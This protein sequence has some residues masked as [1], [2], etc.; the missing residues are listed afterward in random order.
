[1]IRRPAVRL[2]AVLLLLPAAGGA[3]FG[4]AAGE[5]EVKAAFIHNIAKFI[6]WPGKS[7]PAGPQRLCLLGRDGTAVISGTLQGKAIGH[8]TWEPVSVGL[9]DDLRQCHVLFVAASEASNLR[10]IVDAVGRSPVLTV[11]DGEGYGAAG[12]IVN[13]YFEQDK[14]RFEI[15]PGAAGRAGLNVSSQVLRL[16]RIVRDG[17][18]SP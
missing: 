4:Q 10:R 3:A 13:F 6:Q 12:L 16:A 9:R 17:G 8:G 14:V 1:M 15:N 2:L 11:G 5:Y 7:D 18:G